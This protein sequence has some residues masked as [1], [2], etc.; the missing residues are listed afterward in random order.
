VADSGHD[1]VVK[2]SP[3]G[4]EMV[5]VG[6]FSILRAVSVNP[7]DGT[8]WVV[9]HFHNQVVKLSPNGSETVRV[10]GF[11]RP[12]SVAVNPTDGTCWV[13]DPWQDQV[14]KLSPEGSVTVRV[15]LDLPAGLSVNS[16]DGTCWVVDHPYQVVKLSPEGSE[17][18]RVGGFFCPFV[19]VNPTDGTCWV[20]D[21]QHDQ[22]V[23]LSPDGSEIFRVGGFD[24]PGPVSVNPGL[25]LAIEIKLNGIEFHTEDTITIDAHVT[26]GKEEVDVEGKCWVRF[27]DDSLISL[28]NVPKAT[29]PPE[30]DI[31]IPLLPGG[32]TFNGGEPEGEYKA[33]GRLACP[34]TLDY[35]STD[36]KPFTFTP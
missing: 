33:G 30:L 12:H 15:K 23:K 25:P 9:D 1:Q 10:G 34:I 24:G 27:P 2:L 32:Y 35:F 19:S 26:N 11:D 20:G 36:I 21:F 13:S 8:C 7:A 6:G 22:V 18:V 29:L 16:S 4:S 14:V 3:N 17:T 28:L 5:R 31:I